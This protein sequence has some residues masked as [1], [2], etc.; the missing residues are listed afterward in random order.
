MTPLVAVRDI[1]WEDPVSPLEG[2][3]HSEC[4]RCPVN[5]MLWF[6]VQVSSKP[7]LSRV[8]LSHK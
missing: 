1:L 3:E 4:P 6:R 2:R 8:F 7:A 5:S